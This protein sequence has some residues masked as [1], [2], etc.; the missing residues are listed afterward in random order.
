MC[1]LSGLL[2]QPQSFA[3]QVHVIAEIADLVLRDVTQLFVVHDFGADAVDQAAQRQHGVGSEFLGA[4]VS[5]DVLVW[6]AD[7][8]ARRHI[9]VERIGRLLRD[10][11][12][13]RRLLRRDGMVQGVGRGHGADEDQH[14]QA[15]ALLPVVGAVRETDARAGKDQQSANPGRRRSVAF[16]RFVEPRDRG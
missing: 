13:L 16:R 8:G 10:G 7:H 3:D 9:F 1:G 6:I 12:E 2:H 14:D 15:H 11:H 4:H 5:G